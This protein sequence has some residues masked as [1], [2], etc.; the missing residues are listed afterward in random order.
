M[1]IL[2]QTNIVV[3]YVCVNNWFI[4]SLVDDITPPK[5]ANF[6]KCLTIP[7]KQTLFKDMELITCTKVIVYV[8]IISP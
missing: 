7:L 6:P 5:K 3:D 4:I 8:S 2:A 1:N